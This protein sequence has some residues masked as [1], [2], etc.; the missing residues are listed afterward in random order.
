[1]DLPHCRVIFEGPGRGIAR[2][3]SCAI[4]EWR[5]LIRDEAL[6]GVASAVIARTCITKTKISALFVKVIFYRS[7]LKS[8]RN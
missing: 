5:I 7:A 4:T 3:W 6:K 2:S 1:M 8:Q